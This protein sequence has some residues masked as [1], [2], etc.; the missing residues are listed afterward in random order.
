[1]SFF[2]Q[3][4]RFGASTA[5]VDPQD[6]RVSYHKLALRVEEWRSRLSSLGPHNDK[7]LLIGIEIEARADMVAAY[8]AALAGGH[9]VILAAPGSLSPGQRIADIYRPDV[10]LCWTGNRC[11][12]RG[13]EGGAPCPLHPELR[14]L[15]STSGTTG[16]PRLVRLS[17]E[18][19]TSNAAAIADYLGLG[20]RDVGVTT[21]PLHYSYGLSVLHSHLSVGACLVLSDLSVADEG[22]TTLCQTT[23]VTN[24]ALV[25]HQFDLLAARHFDFAALPDLRFVTQAGGRLASAKIRDLAGTGARQGWDFIVMYGQTEAAPRMAYLPPMD[26]QNYP[27][28]IGR[29]IPGGQLSLLAEDGSEIA[30]NGQPGELVYRGPNVMLG[31]ADSRADLVR[32][33]DIDMLR[34]GD[35]AERTGGG[36]FRLCGRAKRF[37]KLY[38]LRINLDQIERALDAAGLRG[39]AVGVDDRL[40]VMT[41]RSDQTEAIRALVATDCTLPESDVSVHVMPDFPTLPNGKTDQQTILAR[42]R[43]ALAHAGVADK[44]R[45][46]SSLLADYEQ[47][48]RRHGLNGGDSFAR[49]GGDSLAYLHVVLAIESRLG[50]VPDG[51][52]HMSIARLDQLVLQRRAPAAASAS[53]PVEGAI[54]ARLLAISCIVLFH[55]NLW[56]ITGGTWLLILLAGYSLARFQRDQMA[57][58]AAWEVARNLLW[59]V[60]PLYFAITIGYDLVRGDVPPEM[61]LL[62]ANNVRDRLP[63]LLAPYWFISLYVQLALSVVLVCLWPSLRRAITRSAFGFGMVATVLTAGIAALIQFTLFPCN[64]DECEA[65]ARTLPMLVRTLPLCLPFLWVGWTIQAARTWRE[66][67]LAAFALAL[68]V[69]SFSIRETGFLTLMVVGAALLLLPVSLRF[70]MVVARLLRRMAA[71][72]LFVYLLHNAVIWLFKFA[73]PIHETLGPVMSALIGLPLCFA[74]A[75]AAEW[76]FRRSEAVVL[77]WIARTF[78][79]RA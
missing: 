64:G 57:R 12:S 50:F 26:A 38:G 20:P 53:V 48:T 22:F 17:E 61:Y 42:A 27:D 46:A 31:Y 79:R 14:L 7:P 49:I 54:I 51:W 59:P 70:P 75:I 13:G 39:A 5:L 52:E 63:A 9:S 16:D 45:A 56:P 6:G 28:T 73:T 36:Y 2:R 18:N 55:L 3:L 1:M 34:T 41:D 29:A 4:G 68:T 62:N 66:K 74:L 11:G 60:V 71:A 21:L 43:S 25:P 37:V 44:R 23:H 47:A 33:R 8:L 40:V 10:T 15:L 67:V 65:V 19:I 35:I 76:L 32:G 24:L 77:R 78:P 72:T 69:A 30:G 58:G